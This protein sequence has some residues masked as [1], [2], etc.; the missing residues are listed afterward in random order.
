M[1]AFYDRIHSYHACSCDKHHAFIYLPFSYRNFYIFF[2][3]TKIFLEIA[4]NWGDEENVEGRETE[5][6]LF[7]FDMPIYAALDGGKFS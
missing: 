3:S 4:K 2:L 6:T 1:I 5:V 7:L